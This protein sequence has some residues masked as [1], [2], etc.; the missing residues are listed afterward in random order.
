[1]TKENKTGGFNR[2]SALVMTICMTAVFA[3]F[4]LI[5]TA[6]TASAQNAESELQ[7]FGVRGNVTCSTYGYNPNG[8]MANVNGKVYII[9]LKN[10][11]IASIE[12]PEAVFKDLDK[13][14]SKKKGLFITQFLIHNDSYDKDHH[15]GEWRGSHHLIPMYILVDYDKSG[16]MV[17]ADRLFS[18]EGAAPGHYHGDIREQKNID[19]AALF[20]N[21]IM[22]FVRK[23]GFAGE[24]T[25]EWP[26]NA[27]GYITANEVNIRTGPG[28]NYR[29]LGVFFKDDYVTLLNKIT[30]ADGDS[31]YEV[32]YYNKQYG[33]I[34]GWVNGNYIREGK[35]F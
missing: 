35:R 23:G 6:G 15:Y 16:N 32:K 17:P 27:P 10:N 9:D 12:N 4:I 30:A 33:W 22:P 26:A 28:E 18:G 7:R 14:N 1:M 25:P 29:S 24:M 11:R 3:V 13:E 34:Q 19:L 31:W 20:V 8:F 2:L 21:E 5:S